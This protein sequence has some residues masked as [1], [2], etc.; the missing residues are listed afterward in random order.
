MR[1]CPYQIIARAGGAAPA[2][3]NAANET[4]VEAFLARRI[5][6]LD[7]AAVVETVLDML[8]G[9]KLGEIAKSPSSFDDVVA[10]DAAG[11]EP[12]ATFQAGDALCEAGLSAQWHVS[13]GV[14]HSIGPDG[15]ELAG[16]FLRTVSKGFSL[17]R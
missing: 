3:L 10:A 16:A 5:G 8:T 6:F 11:V 7:I 2:V 1:L 4:A 15:L 14:P 17:T 13:Y 9:D 12:L